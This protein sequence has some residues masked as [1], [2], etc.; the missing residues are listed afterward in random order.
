MAMV[1]FD[2]PG[3][4]SSKVI[5]TDLQNRRGVGIKDL[6]TPAQYDTRE[7]PWKISNKNGSNELSEM[8]F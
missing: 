4:R 8:L 3:M 6:V 2:L 7:D 5:K 1:K